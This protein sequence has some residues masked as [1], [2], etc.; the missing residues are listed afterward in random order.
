[1]MPNTLAAQRP[2]SSLWLML[3]R[4]PYTLLAV[5]FLIS[6]AVVFCRRADSE[7]DNVFVGAARHLWAGQGL[8]RHG[9]GFL[10]PPFAGVIAGPFLPLPALPG[11]LAWFLLNAVA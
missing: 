6:L 7:W 1:M 5:A 11:R 2:V 8:Y 10:Y 9:D 4:R 3:T